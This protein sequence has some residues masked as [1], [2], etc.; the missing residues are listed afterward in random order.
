MAAIE[1]TYLAIAFDVY[2]HVF[3]YEESNSA[4]RK[5]ISCRYSDIQDKTHFLCALVIF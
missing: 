5:Y 1:I 3:W 2:T 4:H